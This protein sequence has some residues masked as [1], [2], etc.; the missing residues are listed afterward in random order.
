M[1]TGGRL[2]LAAAAL[3]LSCRRASAFHGAF[4]GAA[5]SL[6][7]RSSGTST[8]TRSPSWLPTYATADSATDVGDE[9]RL[10]AATQLVKDDAG[11]FVSLAAVQALPL[12]FTETRLCTLTYF[13]AMAVGTVYLGAKRQELPNEEIVALTPQQATLAPFI[14]G[15]SLLLIY[16]VIKYLNL[17]P[18]DIY[19]LLSTLFGLTSAV[20][21]GVGLA[22]A[23][24]PSSLRMVRWSLPPAL[25]STFSDPEDEN[26]TISL[27][28]AI[29]VFFS[30]LTGALYLSPLPLTSKF[31]AG[32]YIAWTIALQSLGLL[33]MQS[34]ST[35]SIFL[36]G[37]FFY[38]ITAVFLTPYIFGGLSVMETVATKV[39]GPVKFLFPVPPAVIA[40][41]P[42]PF[43]VL[44]LGDVV[45]P[46]LFVALMRALDTHLMEREGEASRDG[47]VSY[48]SS[49]VLAYALGLGACFVVNALT[50]SG[51]PAL[52][53]LNPAMIGSAL[54][55]SF[56]N[57]GEY[58]KLFAFRHLP[59]KEGDDN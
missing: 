19:Q 56:L 18:S 42:Y 57:G 51:Q 40:S 7:R 47:K 44:G 35:A 52:L 21:V 32:N 20:V 5:S 11:V 9:E 58:D 59:D 49:A 43:S 8:T 6:P 55:T 53:Y 34:F 1:R 17:D 37:L 22:G 24:L 48:F 14:S 16:G 54:L 15:A 38:D 36:F 33:S 10:E 13:A 46:G 39:E 27:A 3:V 50:S 23:I 12:F 45:L 29:S 4:G 2:R 25:A 28:G 26:P 30:V 41:R 31:L